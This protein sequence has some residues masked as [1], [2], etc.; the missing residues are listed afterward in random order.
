MNGVGTQRSQSSDT[1]GTDQS[2]EINR[3]TEKVIGSAIEV[4]RML[5]S[6]LL[7]SAYQRAFAHELTL[8][9]ILFEE[10]K[11]CSVRYKEL[12]IQDAYRIDFLVE[13]RVIVEIKAVETL[14]EVHEAQVLTYLKFTGCRVGLLINF[15]SSVLTRDGLRRFVM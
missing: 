11:P 1:E 8:R 3:L 12:A 6:G 4:H 5:G 7:E 13:E 9:K 2:K 10:Q 15:K 14:L